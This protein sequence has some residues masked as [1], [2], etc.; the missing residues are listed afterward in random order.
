[1]AKKSVRFSLGTKLRLLLGPAVLV[2]IAAALVVP[3]R[4]MEL[5]AEQGLQKPGAELT[6]L[7][8]NEFVRDHPEGKDRGK[9]VYR[10]VRDAGNAES[11]SRG[12]PEIIKL[13]GKEARDLALDSYARRAR[14]TFTRDPAE[15]LVVMRSEDQGQTAYRCF[16]A[17][18]AQQT[19]MADTCHGSAADDKPRKPRFGAGQLVAMVDVAMPG[20]MASGRLVLWT[21]VAFAAGLALSSL[22]ALVLFSVIVQ[23]LILRPLRQLRNVSDKVAEGDMTVRSTIATGDELERLGE[24]FNDMLAAIADQHE[25]IYAA[26][27]ALDLKLNELAEANVTLFKA[28]K[29]KSEFLANM[30]HELRTPLNSIMGFAD[31]LVEMGDER[32]GRYGANISTAA[33]NLLAMINDL[34]DLAKIEAGKADVRFDRV[35]VTDACQTLLALM[36][37]LADKKEITLHGEIAD[38]LPIIITDAGKLQQV[39]FNLL[40]NAIKF[41]PAREQVTLSAKCE[42]AGS[43]RALRDGVVISVT[44]TGPGIAEAD[45][46]HLFDKFYQADQSLTKESGGTG[47]GLAIAKELVMLLG[48]RLMLRS[49]PGH[50]STFSLHLPAD[51]AEALRRRGTNGLP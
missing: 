2:I 48:G 29:V 18:R 9:V 21:R 3:W 51:G 38:D 45:Q 20:T 23:R 22:L 27:M 14:K 15:E 41:I 24:S 28:N 7:R 5:L 33:K 32:I 37:P 12:G 35:S 36:R 11:P 46:K 1:M 10:A 16:R 17:V 44:D 30:S 13:L 31:L 40:S 43:D 47:L 42:D 25:K 34:L 49:S 50:G 26:N 8:L 4:F 6:L 19:C 39:L